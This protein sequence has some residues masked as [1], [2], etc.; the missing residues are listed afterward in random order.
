[1]KHFSKIDCVLT[2]M[3]IQKMFKYRHNII[4]SNKKYYQNNNTL[5]KITP[6]TVVL[7]EISFITGNFHFLKECSG[8]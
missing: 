3:T 6:D 4:K 8:A 1:M 2:T 5:L 7:P